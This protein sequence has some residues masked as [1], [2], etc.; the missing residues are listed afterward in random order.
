[1]A[2]L[3]G[4]LLALLLLSSEAAAAVEA[5]A[6]AASNNG[7]DA[8]VATLSA[9]AWDSVTLDCPAAA[10]HSSSDGVSSQVLWVIPGNRLLF[11]G[12]S[13]SEN[14]G[15]NGT[16]NGTS[17]AT[18]APWVDDQCESEAAFLTVSETD[19]HLNVAQNGSLIIRDFGWADRGSYKC[20]VPAGDGDGIV[21]EP[22]EGGQVEV[23]LQATYREHVYYFSLLYG[24]VS[25]SGLLLLTLLFKLVYWL[26]ET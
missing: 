11:M 7:T 25:A 4:L 12:G 1:M 17:P 14:E 20:L 13:R 24:A 9:A 26:L 23:E 18:D 5:E 10:E 21:D 16:L 8:L 19:G 6:A 2:L 15:F 22:E 3:S